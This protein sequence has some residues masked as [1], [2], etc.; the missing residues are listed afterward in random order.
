L[1]M[2]T[3]GMTDHVFDRDGIEIDLPEGFEEV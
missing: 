3:N 1:V 2:I